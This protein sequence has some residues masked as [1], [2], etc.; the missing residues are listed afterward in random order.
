MAAIGIDVGGTFTDFVLQDGDTLHV[1]KRLSTPADPAEAVL[2]G[3]P[4]RL[5]DRVV[6]G[7]TVAT[8]ALLERRGPRTVLV[9]TEGFRD[10]LTI[11]RQTRPS[12]YDLEPRRPAHVVR[13]GD[14]LAVRERLAP[15]G[16][17]LL[18]LT[19]DEV[20]RVVSAAA[21][22]G[23]EAFAI[24]LLHSY[25][26]PSHERRLA[27]AF[28]AAGLPCAASHE[29][30]PEV[31]EYERASTTAIAA[32]LRPTVA[33]YLERLA[34]RVPKL[35]LIHS[36]GGLVDVGEVL[37]RPVVMLLSGPAGGVLGAVATA[38]AAGYERVITFDMGGTSTDVALCPG[39]PVLRN[40]SEVDGLAV[41]VPTIDVVT[42][43]A[44][45]GSVARLDP[46][47]ALLVGP[48]SAGADP[49]PACYGR[50]ARPTVT[51]ANLV[52]GRLRPEQRLGG[53]VTPDL[54]RALAALSTIGDPVPAAAA[55]VSVANATMARAL[56]KVSLERG[57]DPAEFTLVAF[58]GAGPLHACD[59]AEEVGIH[60]VLV[61]RFPGVLSALGMLVAPEAVELQRAA[62]TTLDG[63]AADFVTPL[64]AT[65]EAEAH[66]RLAAF[67]GPPRRVRW[68]ADVR[69][70]GQAHELR[71]PIPEPRPEAIVQAFNAAHL[72]RF[73]FH[74][75][76]RPVELVALRVR[77]EG[78]VADLKVPATPG[79]APAGPPSRARVWVGPSELC[80]AD[81]VRRE[82]LGPSTSLLGPAIIVQDDCTTYVPPGWQ[83]RTD[84]LGNLVLERER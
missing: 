6:H 15:D 53:A 67:A 44:G 77:A 14:S 25:V 71:V 28:R 51:D 63:H 1:W 84:D 54:P 19:D 9:T 27:A 8:N 68:F 61:P 10:L 42:V 65:L 74:A 22:S 78:A 35:R 57:H 58:G 45:G 2:A 30:A 49:G 76:E 43:G 82:A 18:P 55:V 3:L 24:C 52:L 20:E 66:A 12:L 56:R 23:A 50:G 16:E 64:A 5:P 80:E 46:G 34:A 60:R 69:Y 70:V 17:V 75:P 48:E 81:V 41:L 32:F 83:G 79:R 33:R 13:P 36:A 62:V 72:D 4:P 21:A 31:R 29:V 40:G 47:G 38:R 59:L 37:A 26:D 7:S 73:G 39:E 11:R